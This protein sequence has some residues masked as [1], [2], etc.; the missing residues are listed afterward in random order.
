MTTDP[1]PRRSPDAPLPGLR[2]RPADVPPVA[3]VVGDP[4]RA[5]RAAAGL[6]GA[7]EVGRNREY[8]TFVGA[9]D[10]VPLAVVSHGVG[11]AGANLCFIELLDAGVHTLVRAGTCGAIAHGIRDGDWIVATGAVREDAVTEHLVPLPYPAIADR[12]VTD[13]LERAARRRAGYDASAASAERGAGQAG[14]RAVRTGLV[15]T[16]ANFYPWMATPRWQRYRGT[17]TLGVE[18]ELSALLVLAA[19]RGARAGGILTVDGNLL[20]KDP[21][22]SDYDPHREVVETGVV[23][24][25][26]VALEAAAALARDPGPGTEEAAA[27]SGGDGARGGPA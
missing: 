19:A 21:A 16:E 22:M 6:E 2:L 7:R 1:P 14:R 20:E 3:V 24:M 13:A 18:M 25:L 12:R 10:G 27:R 26:D 11:A 17:G 4:D 15:V 8:R 9:R 5:E 23:E